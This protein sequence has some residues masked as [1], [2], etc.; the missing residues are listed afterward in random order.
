METRIVIPVID[1][2][3]QNTS[4]SEHFGRAPFF[5]LVVIND[6]GSIMT[7]EIIPNRSEH[8]GG[9]GSPVDRILQ[10]EPNTVITYGMGSRGLNIF[11][12]L[13]SR[14]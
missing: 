14:C 3:F 6:E 10:L 12:E 4:L 7:R 13:E 8:F 5:T 2:S 1:D 9:V 11:Q